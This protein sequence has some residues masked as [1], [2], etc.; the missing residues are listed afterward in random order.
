[1]TRMLSILQATPGVTVQDKGRPGY[2]AQGLSRGGGRRPAGL[3]RGGGA[4]GPV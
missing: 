3:G 4:V 1:M 2:L